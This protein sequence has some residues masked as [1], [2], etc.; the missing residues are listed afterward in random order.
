MLTI[1]ENILALDDLADDV[2]RAFLALPIVTEFQK[3]VAQFEADERLQEKI[4]RLEENRAFIAF[5]PEIRE[6]QKEILM[7]ETIYQLKISENDVQTTLSDL[8]KEVA[9]TVSDGIVVDENLP[10][11]K[12]GHHAHHRN[13]A[14]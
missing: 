8:A 5:R 3:K 1:D 10:F 11:K 7:D 14:K 2:A 9:S 6:L 4:Q 13:N 12:G